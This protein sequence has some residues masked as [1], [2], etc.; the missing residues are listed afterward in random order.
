[1]VK[2]SALTFR[3]K[4]RI[5]LMKAHLILETLVLKRGYAYDDQRKNARECC[6]D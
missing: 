3:Q 5:I 4:G 6:C 1:M 2:T